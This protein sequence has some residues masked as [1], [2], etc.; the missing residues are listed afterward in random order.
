MKSACIY[1]R[2]S[3][4]T[5]KKGSKTEKNQT[6]E[7]QEII[8][9]DFAEK[10]DYEIVKIYRDRASGKNNDRDEFKEMLEDAKNGKFKYLLIFNLDRLTRMGSMVTLNSLHELSTF[11]VETISYSEQYIS[12]AEEDEKELLISIRLIWQRK[13]EKDYKK[14]YKLESIG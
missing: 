3:T 9:I 13:N 8:L 6:T 14:G 1:A 7:N 5:F 4:N 12:D 11:G 10:N 2:V